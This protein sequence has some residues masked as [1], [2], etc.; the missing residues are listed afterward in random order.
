MYRPRF[1]TEKDLFPRMM[2]H[3]GEPFFLAPRNY[4]VVDADTI[5]VLGRLTRDQI[6]LGDE[7][8]E[9]AFRIRHR[10]IAA[11]EMPFYNQFDR[12][13]KSKGMDIHNNNPAVVAANALKQLCRNR[14]IFVEPSGRK[15]K[16]GRMLGDIAVSGAR[17][18]GFEL[19]GALSTEWYLLENGHVDRFS[20]D[21]KIPPYTPF[22]LQNLLRQIQATPDMGL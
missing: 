9:I 20:D 3:P 4:Y 19:R 8:R 10:T 6:A 15:D 22:I 17:G 14:A 7:K 18:A 13:L 1:L 21:E 2:D 12:M 5:A 16:Y 11:P